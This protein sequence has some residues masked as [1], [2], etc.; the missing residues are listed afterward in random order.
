MQRTSC[1]TSNGG[2]RWRWCIATFR[3]RTSSLQAADGITRITD[4]GVARAALAGLTATGRVGQL[5]GKIAY[6][7]PEQA[8]RRS[9]PRSASRHLR[10]RRRH[11]GGA[12]SQAALQSRERSG[13][14]ARVINDP[15]PRLVKTSSPRADSDRCR[16][17]EGVD[18]ARTPLPDVRRVCR[19]TRARGDRTGNWRQS[20]HAKPTSRSGHFGA[21]MTALDNLPRPGLRAR[22]RAAFASDGH[23]DSSGLS[24][25]W[26]RRPRPA[27]RV[28]RNS[29]GQAAVGFGHWRPLSSWAPWASS[30]FAG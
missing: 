29:H 23:P 10:G 15:I 28:S 17:R 19:R 1:G 14:L 30:A 20:R 21:E 4:F 11:L 8:A 5:K 18:Q 22:C 9:G 12:G 24:L 25:R 16:S 13:T 2:R 27:R 6:M 3:R 7:A 26:R